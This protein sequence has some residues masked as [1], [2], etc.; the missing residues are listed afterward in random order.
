MKISTAIQNHKYNFWKIVINKNAIRSN[1]HK[2]HQ[3]SDCIKSF[4][5]GTPK[6]MLNGNSK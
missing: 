4:A 3:E 2:R 1:E 5:C 6:E